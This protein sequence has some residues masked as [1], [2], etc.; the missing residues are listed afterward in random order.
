MTRRE[1]K[2]QR[3]SVAM[4]SKKW[5]SLIQQVWHT[6]PLRCPVCQNPMRMIPVIDHREVVE[7]I[8]RHLGL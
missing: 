4:P 3:K 8:L 6:D 5:R 7:K 1:V 2:M